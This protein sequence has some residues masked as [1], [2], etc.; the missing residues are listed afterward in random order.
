MPPTGGRIEVVIDNDVIRRLDLS[1][2]RAA[3]GITSP[4]SGEHHVGKLKSNRLFLN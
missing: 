1:P 3:T 2:F 4:S